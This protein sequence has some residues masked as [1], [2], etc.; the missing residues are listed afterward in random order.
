MK[1]PIQRYFGEGTYFEYAEKFR[2]LSL[3]D[4]PQSIGKYPR[5]RLYFG[6]EEGVEQGALLFTEK[7][8]MQ[9]FTGKKTVIKSQAI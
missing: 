7:I 6:Y 5:Q 4:V 2:I 8:T 9:G 1:T 3:N